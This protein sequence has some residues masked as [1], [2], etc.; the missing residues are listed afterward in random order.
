[1]IAFNRN[2]IRFGERIE[3]PSAELVANTLGL[4]NASVEDAV[5]YGG[6]LTRAALSVL[7]ITNSRKYVVVDTKVHMLMPGFMPAIP[8]WH[9]DGVPRG[10]DGDPLAKAAPDLDAQSQ[11][12]MEG[13]GTRFA[14]LVTGVGCRTE[15]VGTRL[16]LEPD[17]TWKTPH[18]YAGLSEQVERLAPPITTA[19]EC[20]A[21]LFDWW[22]IHRGVAAKA[23]EWRFFIRV[24]ESDLVAPWSDLRRVIRTQQQV[25]VP[26]DRYGW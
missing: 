16:D 6:D 22:D 20:G 13:R 21:V 26:S 15:F 9:T 25:Y 2:P 17:D 14:M 23:H 19:P 11:L 24:T 8:G 3:R 18:L 10:P 7:P 1:M 12:T 4:V 5:R